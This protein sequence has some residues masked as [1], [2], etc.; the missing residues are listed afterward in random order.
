MVV[1]LRDRPAPLR[2]VSTTR[3]KGR[4]KIALPRVFIAGDACHTHSPKAGQ[5][6]NVSMQDGFNL[7]WK[8]ASVLRGRCSPRI[9]Q[10]YSDERQAIAKELIDFDRKW[11][12]MFSAPPKD[13]I[14][15][16]QRRRRSGGV[17]EILRQAGAL[18][19]GNG[20][21]VRPVD[22]LGRADLSA[23][24]PKALRSACAFIRRRS[25]GWPTRGRFNWATQ[26]RRMAAG[27]C[28]PSPTPK[29]PPRRPRGCGLSASFSPGPKTLPSEDTRRQGRISTP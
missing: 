23:P 28:S 19:G 17:P 21:P 2:Q 20:N 26:S 22:D 6:M 24:R 3:R 9:L 1:G 11:A 29:T 14:E 25:S 16:R 7:G 27:G 18:H 10:T 8:L 12:K 5:G 15:R 13:P 4:G